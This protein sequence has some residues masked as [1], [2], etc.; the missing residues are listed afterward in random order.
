MELPFKIELTSIKIETGKTPLI[1]HLIVLGLIHSFLEI[2]NALTSEINPE[3]K[4]NAKV[5]VNPV[6][7]KF[8]PPNEN[9]YQKLYIIKL[10]NN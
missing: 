8:S 6:F 5:P 3:I 1:I 4:S 10:Y 7:S 2:S 9:L